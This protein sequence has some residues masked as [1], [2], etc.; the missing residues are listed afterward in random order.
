MEKWDTNSKSEEGVSTI[1]PNSYEHYLNSDDM[2]L[3]WVAN[4]Y[5][6]FE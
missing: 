5:D 3:D 6:F 4:P 1:L 2:Y